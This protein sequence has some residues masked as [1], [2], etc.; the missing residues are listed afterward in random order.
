MGNCYRTGDWVRVLQ[1]HGIPLGMTQSM[2]RH[3]GHEYQIKFAT[4][5]WY[6]LS[7][8]VNEGAHSAEGWMWAEEWLEPVDVAFEYNIDVGELL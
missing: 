8:P 6:E 4:D 7:D 3:M 5:H 2:I 1:F